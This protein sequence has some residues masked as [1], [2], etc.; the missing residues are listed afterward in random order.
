MLAGKLMLP[1]SGD[2]GPCFERTIGH[3]RRF[4]LGFDPKSLVGEV[5]AIRGLMAGSQAAK[6]GLQDG[7]VVTYAQALDGV[8]GDQAARLTLQVTRAGK[9]FPISYLPRGEEVEVYQWVRVP[10]VPDAKCAY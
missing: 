3:A 5:K 2:F 10:G 1:E 9:T 6:A 4:E 7:D 8:Q